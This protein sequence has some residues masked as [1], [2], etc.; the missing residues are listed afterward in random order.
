MLLFAVA[1]ASMGECANSGAGS[2]MASVGYETSSLLR[3]DT[4]KVHGRYVT[5][6]IYPDADCVVTHAP[7]SAAGNGKKND[8]ASIQRALDDESCGRIVVPQPGTFLVSAL[9]VTQ[10]NTEFHIEEGATLLVSNNRSSWPGS[11]HVITAEKLSHIAITGAGTI[12]GQGLIWWQHIEEFRPHMVQFSDVTNAILQ[13]TLYLDSPNHVLELGC[14]FCELARVKVLAPPSTGS[15]CERHNTCSHNTD[16]VDIHGSPFFVHNVNFTTGDDNIAAHA[17]DTIV[18]D[19]YFGTGH[20][21]SIGSLCDDYLTNIT[22][23]NIEFRGTTSGARIKSHPNCS[24][25]VWDVKYENLTMINV[26]TP[27]D[28][29]QH[30]EGEGS[31]TFLFE[32]ILFKDIQVFAGEK[33][34][35]KS[36]D[37]LADLNAEDQA[38]DVEFDCDNHYDG[39]ANCRVEM[40]NLQFSGFGEKG[41]VMV[42]KGTVGTATKLKGIHSCL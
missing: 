31:S 10:S 32:D 7:Y 26:G 5:V 18:E 3:Q 21:A 41:A 35:R 11:Q 1:S 16:A 8:T 24:G 20:G 22:F 39:K 23:R 14:S 17:N 13:D 34:P 36:S 25:H 19:S 9:V 28:I 29:T 2:S 30:Y 4:R 33:L 40:E 37:R 6:S 15:Q 38:A 12:D 27:I 42:C